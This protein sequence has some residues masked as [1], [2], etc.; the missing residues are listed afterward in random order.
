MNDGIRPVSPL[1]GPSIQE[2]RGGD[3]RGGDRRQQGSPDELETPGTALVPAG[4]V[5][6]VSPAKP[7]A[8]PSVPPAA[9]T[10]QIMGQTGQKRGL[11][12]GPPVLDAARAT[13]LGTEYSGRRDRRPPPGQDTEAE[14]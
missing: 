5:I 14:I 11:K 2:R 3:R 12:G 7:A 9:F 6:D 13:Y 4:P 8:L 10:A 1:A